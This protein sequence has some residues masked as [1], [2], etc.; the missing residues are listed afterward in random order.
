MIL[1]TVGSSVQPFARLLGAMDEMAPRLGDPVVLQSEAPY[2]AR[3]AECVGYV[4]FGQHHR[5]AQEC[6]TLVGHASTG[7]ILLARRYGK[8]LVLVPRVRD[9]GETFDDHQLQ[10]ARAADGRSRMIEVVYDIANLE[11]AVRRALAKADQGLAFEV[12]PL[13]ESLLAAIRA[14]VGGGE[15]SGT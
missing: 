7:A 15:A 13:R 3:N 12:D 2:A 10:T 11:P 5:L 9:L 6:R 4:T 14:A 1:V 8:P